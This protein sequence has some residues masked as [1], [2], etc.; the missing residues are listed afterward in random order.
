MVL[1]LLYNKRLFNNVIPSNNFCFKMHNYFNIS[2]FHT[3][4]SRLVLKLLYNRRLFHYVVPS[5]IPPPPLHNGSGTTSNY[6][7]LAYN[8]FWSK[9]CYV[10]MQ[11]S[12]TERYKHFL[13]Y[14]VDVFLSFIFSKPLK[15][16][17]GEIFRHIIKSKRFYIC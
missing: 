4:N 14:I 1:V 5:N 13:K 10:M 15:I 16:C 3:L 2:T 9:L 17:N 8:N 6:K 12:Y 7:R 11:S